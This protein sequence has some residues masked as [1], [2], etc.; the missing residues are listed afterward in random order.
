MK[1]IILNGVRCTLE[2]KN[3]TVEIPAGWS[4]ERLKK[5]KKMYRSAAISY[6]STEEEDIDFKSPKRAVI[7]K[8]G[9]V[10][11]W[12]VYNPVTDKFLQGLYEEERAIGD[13]ESIIIDEFEFYPKK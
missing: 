11:C 2:G 13:D 5:W 1:T 6:L 4:G 10:I 7:V 8:N 9:E 12:G 3:L